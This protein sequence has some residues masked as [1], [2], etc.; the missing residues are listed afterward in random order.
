MFY[1]LSKTA[2]VLL[3]A[4]LMHGIALLIC[5]ILICFPATRKAGQ[6]MLIGITVLSLVITVIPVGTFLIQKL[7][8]RFEKPD[9]DQTEFAGVIALSGAL[10]AQTYLEHGEVTFP[11]APDRIFNMLD[12]ANQYPN[13]P[14]I[15]TGGDGSLFD[16]GFSEA[17]VLQ[18]W[19]SDSNLLTPNMYFETAAKNTHQNAENTRKLVYKDWPE[20]SKQPWLLVTSAY[21]MPRAVGTFRKAGW[22]VIAYPVGRRTSDRLHLTSLNVSGA[23]KLLGR[24][25][26]EWVGLTAYYVTGR[27]DEW[28]P[29]PKDRVN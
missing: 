19:L 13:K 5:V 21:H 14:I 8:T 29:D 22:N 2:G 17:A 11:I 15:Y 20:L 26:R 1:F 4:T 10:N 7:E 3:N 24:G 25:L 27:T 9:L 16:R 6:V 18:K 12:L 28:F 23:I